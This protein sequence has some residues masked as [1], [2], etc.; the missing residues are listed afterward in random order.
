[1]A[2]GEMLRRLPGRAGL[3]D[4]V[5]FVV[6]IAPVEEISC[7][8]PWMEKQNHFYTPRS[9]WMDMPILCSKLSKQDFPVR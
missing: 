5:S 7:T 8:L 9:S 1:M 4:E 2:V 6:T 3:R